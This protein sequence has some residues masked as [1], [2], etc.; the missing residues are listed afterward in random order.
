MARKETLQEFTK[1]FGRYPEMVQREA[2]T[3][4]NQ[5]TLAT[6]GKAIFYAPKDKGTLQNSARSVRAVV[7]PDGIKSAFIFAVP[8]AFRL[9]KGKDKAGKT[10]NI[11]T[12]VN[13]NAQ[14]GYSS[15]AVD[16]QEPFF[17]SGL[18]KVISKAFN[19]I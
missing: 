10:L 9:E 8:Y 2:M 7:T 15:R 14:K 4:W 1:N 13:P 11:K 3:M 12:I 16:E 19:R 6:V 18:K 17:I 5:E